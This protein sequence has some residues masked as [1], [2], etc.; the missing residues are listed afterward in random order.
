ML[1]NQFSNVRVF[2][3]AASDQPRILR[4]TTVGSNGGVVTEYANDQ[5]YYLLVQSLVLDDCLAEEARIDL[6]KMDIEAHEPIALRGMKNL[7]AKHHPALITEFHPWAMQLN[8]PEPPEEFLRDLRSLGYHISIILP[9]GELLEAD[10]PEL[11]MNYWKS[12]GIETM[13]L[14]LLAQFRDLV[15]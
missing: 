9:S 5:K 13:H 1:D 12:L 3:Y 7:V 2:P 11:I 6:I 4:F 8:N 15:K 14:D 10:S